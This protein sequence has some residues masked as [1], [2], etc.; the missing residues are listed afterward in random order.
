MKLEITKT[1]TQKVEIEIDFPYYYKHD[2][3]LDGADAVIFGKIEAKKCTTIGLTHHSGGDKSYEL[4]IQRKE[5]RNYACYMTAEHKSSE[6][7]YLAAKREL[8]EAAG[9]A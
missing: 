6:A 9:N 5:A 3:M 4:E 1:V 2:L 7:E 8:I